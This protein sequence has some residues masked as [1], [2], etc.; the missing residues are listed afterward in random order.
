[1]TVGSFLTEAKDRRNASCRSIQFSINEPSHL[2]TSTPCYVLPL[3]APPPPLRAPPPP[4][5]HTCTGNGLKSRARMYIH[6]TRAS[7]SR[8][9]T[10]PAPCP[11]PAGGCITRRD[12]WGSAHV[13]VRQRS[14]PALPWWPGQQA[15]Q[16]SYAARRMRDMPFPER[17]P[18][19]RMD[20]QPA[21]FATKGAP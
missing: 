21:A 1:M 3:G 9:C 6:A 17:P 15:E 10:Y 13:A 8:Q 11:S 18:S 16:G 7:M 14:L 5:P 2:R 12:C 4:R 19:A 20:E